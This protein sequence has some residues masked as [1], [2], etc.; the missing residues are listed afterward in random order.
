MRPMTTMINIYV[1]DCDAQY[2]KA[3]RAGAKSI[4]PVA[5]QPY[6][7]RSGGVADAWG[8]EWFIATP[9]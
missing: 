5:D 1:P 9:L 8:N 3:L 2:E 4:M 6:G 7:V